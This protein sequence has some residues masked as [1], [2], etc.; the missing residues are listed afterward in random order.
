VTR[1]QPVN[2]RASLPVS[3]R[4]LEAGEFAKHF[5]ALASLRITV[6][7]DWPYLYE[8]DIAYERAY[9]S[10][11]MET[12]G[13]V[14]IGAF[15]G[16]RLV[17]ASTAAPLTDHHGEFA[18]PLQDWGLD[19]DDYFYFGESVLLKA[20]RGTGI[21]VRF[22]EER[23][24]AALQQ[25]FTTTV[26]SSVVRPATHPARPAD[27]QPLDGFWSRRGYERLPGLVAHY[28]WRDIGDA[29]ETPKPMEFWRRHLV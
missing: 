13:A 23:E 21:G 2:A 17:G 15:D 9:L 28:A 27:Y 18:Q 5:D 22:F 20:W 12:P 8:G 4:R 16:K 6:F 26:F 7:R 25:R 14:I 10:A 29:E 3:V 19:P 1:L 11:Y 24:Q